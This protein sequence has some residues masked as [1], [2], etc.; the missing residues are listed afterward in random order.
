[1]IKEASLKYN[2]NIL[3]KNKLREQDREELKEKE[4]N[5]KKIMGIN[6]KDEW[7]LDKKLYR[8]VLERIKKIEKKDVQPAK[9]G[10]LKVQRLSVFLHEEDHKK[11]AYPITV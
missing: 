10:R 9:Q 3:A 2:V 4:E 8:K 1:M 6:K 7:E 5:H 11:G